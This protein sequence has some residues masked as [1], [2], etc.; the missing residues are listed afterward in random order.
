MDSASRQLINKRV[1]AFEKIERIRNYN[2]VN[3]V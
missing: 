3:D 2:K 1:D